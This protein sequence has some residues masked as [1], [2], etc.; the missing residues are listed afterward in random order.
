ME[1]F[2]FINKP[3]TSLALTFNVKLTFLQ[4][5][6]F[7]WGQLEPDL[8]ILGPRSGSCRDVMLQVPKSWDAGSIAN[9]L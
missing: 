3:N 6:F 5:I 4:G 7:A 1:F 8:N 9:L 2:V